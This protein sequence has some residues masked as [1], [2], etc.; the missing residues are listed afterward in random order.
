MA[1]TPNTPA[2]ENTRL[3]LGPYPRFVT[4]DFDVPGIDQMAVYR[5]HG[6]YEALAEALRRYPPDEL[7]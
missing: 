1:T 7:L 2:T 4:P 6:G 5:E 3:P